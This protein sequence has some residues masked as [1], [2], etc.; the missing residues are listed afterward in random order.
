VFAACFIWRDKEKLSEE[1]FGAV[2]YPS[3]L[4]DSSV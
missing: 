3:C 2:T 1:S 4:M